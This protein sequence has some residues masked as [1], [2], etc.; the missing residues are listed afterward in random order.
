V[1]RRWFGLVIGGCAAA[2]ACTSFSG[3]ED[4]VPGP[5]DAAPDAELDVAPAPPDASDAGRCSIVSLAS[6]DLH[7]CAVKADGKVW[8]WGLNAAGQLGIGN[9]ATVVSRPTPVIDVTNAVEVAAGPYH[10]C[11]RTRAGEVWCWGA[12][13]GGQLGLGT[14][15]GLGVPPTKVPGVNDATAI[16]V[17][18]AHTCAVRANGVVWCWGLNAHGQIG[19]AKDSANEPAPVQT[20]LAE[21]AQALAL[22]GF[23]TCALTQAGGVWCW[24]I[25]NAGQ[26]GVG[27]DD[28]GADAASYSHRSAEQAIVTGA[29]DIASG[30]AHA[31]ATVASGLQCWGANAALQLASGKTGSVD[32]P[33]PVIVP[34]GLM[35]S[36]PSAG[37]DATCALAKDGSGPWCWGSNKYGLLNQ[38]AAGPIGDPVKVVTKAT[39]VHVGAR[40][41]CVRVDEGPPQCWGTSEYGQLG[42]GVIDPDSGAPVRVGPAPITTIC[43]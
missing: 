5:G 37:S 15:T 4:P 21:P 12:N 7:S 3:D 16:A 26:L 10:S 23:H 22:A 41:A 36:A 6:G 18:F 9:N 29:G 13:N 27:F 20:T 14:V 33:S 1:V 24:G 31:C 38:S 32:R 34:Q 19:N 40:H 43:D 8:C 17:G 25:N 30:F 35:L 39:R 42:R 11:A 2:V 28:A